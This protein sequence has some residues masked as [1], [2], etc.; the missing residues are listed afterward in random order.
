MKDDLKGDESH[1]SVTLLVIARGD[2][3]LVLRES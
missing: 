3:S 1:H 2:L